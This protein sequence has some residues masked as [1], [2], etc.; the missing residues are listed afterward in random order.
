MQIE[1]SKHRAFLVGKAFYSTVT[2]L[3]VEHFSAIERKTSFAAFRANIAVD[4]SSKM[5]FLSEW[6][7]STHTQNTFW[8][9]TMC[10][11]YIKWQSFSLVAHIEHWTSQKLHGNRRSKYSARVCV[12]KRLFTCSI[13]ASSLLLCIACEFVISQCSFFIFCKFLFRTS[14]DCHFLI[15]SYIFFL[16]VIRLWFGFPPFLP[17]L[18]RYVRL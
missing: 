13:C 4:W 5:I 8:S 12:C 11:I 17:P 9:Y 18:I 7:C 3:Y 16:A 6:T 1:H 2:E 15:F 14:F 10:E